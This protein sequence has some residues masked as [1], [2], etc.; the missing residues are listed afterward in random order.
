[1]KT[2]D[3][4]RIQIIVD[5]DAMVDGENTTDLPQTGAF[6]INYDKTDLIVRQDGLNGEYVEQ[7]AHNNSGE[8]V[9][10]L[11]R[12]SKNIEAIVSRFKTPVAVMEITLP[13][14]LVLTFEGVSLNRFEPIADLELGTDSHALRLKA[15]NIDIQ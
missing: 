1:M 10:P 14:G 7:K 4:R 12:G 2:F 13:C 8:V 9:I 11:L 3:V 5:G 15:Y 6:T